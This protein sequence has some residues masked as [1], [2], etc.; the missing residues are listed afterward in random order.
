MAILKLRHEKFQE[1]LH[2]IE[3]WL[4]RGSQPGPKDFSRLFDAGIRVIVNLRKHDET[5]DIEKFAPGI[6]A[7]RIPMP[8]HQPP[9]VTQ[10]LKW[11]DLCES[12][13]SKWQIF[14]HC[15]AG[16]GRTSVF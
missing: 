15:H 11:L 7:V 2:R 4:M 14:V 3:P 12:V 8:N 13:R 9:S 6:L 5:Q 16:H 10:A 1:R